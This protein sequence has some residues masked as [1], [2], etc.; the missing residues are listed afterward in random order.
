[1][2]STRV[3][4]K[5]RKAIRN[6]RKITRTM[7]LIATARFKKAMDRTIEADAYTRKIAELAADL[8]A[9]AGDI[10]HPLLEKRAVVKNSVLLILCS[11]RGL[12]GGYN[13]SILREASA[14][15]PAQAPASLPSVSPV[16]SFD[17]W[18]ALDLSAPDGTITHVVAARD[19]S[20]ALH[21]TRGGD[22]L[23]VDGV[24]AQLAL[25]DLDQDGVVE[26]VMTA[27][28]GPDALVVS[29]WRGGG[30][31]ERMR[32]AAPAGVDAV[33]VC[34]PELKGA[35][36]LVAAVGREIWLVR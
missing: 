8:S 28:S 19:P 26:V 17:A 30:L 20:G 31:V 7:E 22:Q 14:H 15:L 4:V 3:L 2:A 35:P 5:R 23:T 12:C 33:G 29:T 13:G 6:I 32:I 24:G 16:P 1:M 9:N 25:A 34:P 18:S 21:L 11:N 10:K 36:A 27:P